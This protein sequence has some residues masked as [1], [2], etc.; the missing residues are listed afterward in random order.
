MESVQSWAELVLSGGALAGTSK[1][2]NC[3]MSCGTAAYRP[4]NTGKG[5]SSTFLLCPMPFR[6]QEARRLHAFQVLPL[7]G[8]LGRAQARHCQATLLLTAGCF[9]SFWSFRASLQAASRHS[10]P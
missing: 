10:L 3:P 5:I 9:Y 8:R 6:G 2:P 1:V 4:W 7:R